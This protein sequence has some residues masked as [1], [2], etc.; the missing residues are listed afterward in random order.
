MRRW[1]PSTC[2]RCRSNSRKSHARSRLCSI[3]PL[4][5]SRM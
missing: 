5:P 4:C 3:C 2:G 1:S